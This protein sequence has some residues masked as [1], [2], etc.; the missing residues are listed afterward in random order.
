MIGRALDFTAIEVEAEIERCI[1]S[2]EVTSFNFD[3]FSITIGIGIG[4]TVG[5]QTTPEKLIDEADSALYQAKGRG[6]NQVFAYD[7]NG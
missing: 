4:H 3:G 2:R 1:A 7:E 5:G 6:E